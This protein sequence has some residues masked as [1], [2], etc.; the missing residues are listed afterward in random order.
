MADSRRV[1]RL[2]ARFEEEIAARDTEID[3]LRAMTVFVERE[4][5]DAVQRAQRLTAN[6]QE[7]RQRALTAEATVAELQGLRQAEADAQATA[8]H[9]AFQGGMRKVG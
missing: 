7:F 3:R 9:E 4:R 5:D 1:R 8:R 6:L 2:R